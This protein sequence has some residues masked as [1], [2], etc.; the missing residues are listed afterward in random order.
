[1]RVIAW[2]KHVRKQTQSLVQ[3][4][5]TL[6]LESQP[7]LDIP[8]DPE[9]IAHLNCPPAPYYSTTKY[10]F[11]RFESDAISFL[12]E[13]AGLGEIF[14]IGIY[15]FKLSIRQELKTLMKDVHWD[16]PQKIE[17]LIN[18]G[19]C[20]K[21]TPS[22]MLRECRSIPRTKIKSENLCASHTIHE[23]G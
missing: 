11:S 16:S 15:D 10:V 18:V 6:W 1:M 22:L 7:K 17:T 14:R 2:T 20:Q 19:W 21:T 3:L 5:K 4:S 8:S 12:Q 23:Q 9:P 13:K